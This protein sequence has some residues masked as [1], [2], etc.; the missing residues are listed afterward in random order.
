MSLFR[1]V[2]LLKVSTGEG[3]YVKGKWVP[4][5]SVETAFNGTC[6]LQAERFLKLYRKENETKIPIFVTP[7]L[8]W[9]LQVQTRKHKWLVI[10]LN[11]KISC[12]K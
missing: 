4:G 1:T 10:A 11:G 5:T 12:M 7:Q 6:N 8:I 9:N 2:S 3:Q